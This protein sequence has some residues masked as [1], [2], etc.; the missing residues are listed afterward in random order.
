[1][2]EKWNDGAIPYGSRVVTISTVTYV[3]NNIRV[4]RPTKQIKRTNELDEPSGSV[5]VED[6]V[7]G[8]AELQLATSSTAEPQNGM[9]FDLTLDAT[10]GEETFILSEVER[11]EEKSADKKLNVNF[12]KQYN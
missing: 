10:I 1:M 4:R 3:A 7:E 5:G 11:P 9:T 12:I 8:S 2:S 6:F